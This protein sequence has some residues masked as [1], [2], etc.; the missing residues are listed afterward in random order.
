MKF[1]AGRRT[2]NYRNL[3]YVSLGEASTSYD[4][5]LASGSSTLGFASW[6]LVRSAG[7]ARPRP[8]PPTRDALLTR[9]GTG[10]M[11]GTPR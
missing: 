10:G 4:F 1:K 3:G 8:A 9:S 6:R 11:S 2:P 5:R 7:R